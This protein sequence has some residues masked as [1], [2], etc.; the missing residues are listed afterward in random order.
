[1][2]LVELLKDRDLSL[3]NIFI[4]DLGVKNR[5]MQLNL[6]TTT[7]CSG[8]ESIVSMKG[9]VSYIKE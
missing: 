4:E 7:C 9:N 8:Q 2:L 1:M 6:L 5:R 3:F